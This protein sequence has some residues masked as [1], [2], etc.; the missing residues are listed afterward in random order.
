MTVA[1]VEYEEVQ[2]FLGDDHEKAVE[3]GLE[4]L[5]HSQRSVRSRL[6]EFT[7][8]EALRN[9]LQKKAKAKAKRLA[10]RR[11]ALTG[12]EQEKKLKARKE[13]NEMLTKQ[14]QETGWSVPKLVGSLEP[15]VGKKLSAAEHWR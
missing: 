9:T 15:R 5:T 2:C 1:G 3:K 4:R 14:A 7:T 12:E 13:T 10:T 6:Q 8:S 11:A